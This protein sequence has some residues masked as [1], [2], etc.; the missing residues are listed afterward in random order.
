M[1]VCV[2]VCVGL[3]VGLC[4]CCVMKVMLICDIT[5]THARTH[6][7]THTHLLVGEVELHEILPEEHVADQDALREKRCHAIRQQCPP[8]ASMLCHDH[9][10][11]RA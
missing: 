3:C 6:A 5:P 4:E 9:C 2:C 8:T 7:R 10:G 1:C 11:T